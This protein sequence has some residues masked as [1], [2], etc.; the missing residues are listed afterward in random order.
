VSP[1][2]STSRNWR[3]TIFIER[4]RKTVKYE[5]VYLTAYE[6]LTHGGRGPGT[7]FDRSN[8]RLPRQGLADRT[9]DEV[10]FRSLPLMRNAV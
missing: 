5:E 3:G 7:F 2:S 4:L 6:S 9:P 8:A 1:G 10:Y